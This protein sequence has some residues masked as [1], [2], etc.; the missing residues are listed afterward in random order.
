MILKLLLILIVLKE[1]YKLR[2]LKLIYLFIKFSV[3]MMKHTFK[4]IIKNSKRTKYFYLSKKFIY[5]NIIK[6]KSFFFCFFCFENQHSLSHHLS[7]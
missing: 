1:T 3:Y 5:C 7:L 4:K 6:I 2:N